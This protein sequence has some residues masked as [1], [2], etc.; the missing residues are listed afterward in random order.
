MLEGGPS[1]S[2][3]QLPMRSR[4][5]ARRWDQADRLALSLETLCAVAGIGGGV[6]LVAR[7]AD[8]MPLRYLS[9]TVFTSWRWPGVALL[10]LVGLGAALAAL[11]ELRRWPV[12]PWGHVAYGIGLVAWVCLEAAWVVVFLPLQVPFGIVGAV[13]AARG[14][15]YL[16]EHH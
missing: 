1:V 8:A 5:R 16:S 3:V 10:V 4:R 12:A 6:D 2:T 7:P 15:V 11:A 14:F 9:G 13:I